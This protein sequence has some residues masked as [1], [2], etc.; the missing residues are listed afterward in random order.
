MFWKTV[1]FSNLFNMCQFKLSGYHEL[2]NQI[3]SNFSSNL[4]VY[5]ELLVL[6]LF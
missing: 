3:Q 6:L 5:Y 1:V 2:K 4:F